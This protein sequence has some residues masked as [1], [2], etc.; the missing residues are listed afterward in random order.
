MVVAKS[1]KKKQV[2]STIVVFV[3]LIYPVL[4]T[5]GYDHYNFAF[6]IMTV[7]SILALFRTGMKSYMP[8]LLNYYFLFWGLSHV[9]MASSISSI[10]PIGVIRTYLVYNML[11]KEFDYAK[12]LK[13]YN[14]LVVIF[15][16]FFFFQ[17]FIYASTGY[18]VLGV[19][20]SLP[21]ALDVE[22]A[23]SHLEKMITSERS[24]SFFSEPAHF[25]QFL[26]PLFALKLFKPLRRSDRVIVLGIFI[27][28]LLMQSG[29]AL[30]G[31]ATIIVC[32]IFSKYFCIVN[33]RKIIGLLLLSSILAIGTFYYLKADMGQYIIERQDQLNADGDAQSGQSGF[34]RIFRGYYVYGALS[35]IEMIIGADDIKRIDSAINSSGVAWAFKKNDYYFNVVQGLLIRTGVIGMVVFVLFLLWG[36]RKTD[37]SGK[38]ILLTFISLSFISSLLFTPTM[39]LYLLLALSLKKKKGIDNDSKVLC[40]KTAKK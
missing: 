30:L 34:L 27:A 2:F 24:S 11:F 7:L 6:I 14:I 28:L 12:C 5:Y 18:R 39:A 38:A 1:H 29:N 17:E 33:A 22:D 37:S 15:L 36:L 10:I 13:I 8:K 25:V 26:L 20:Q 21:L 32:F 19:S 9:L 3:L 40:I 4:Q 35:P 23:S 16:S 31:L